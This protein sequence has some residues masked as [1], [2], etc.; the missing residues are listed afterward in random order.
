MRK[1]GTTLLEV[2]VAAVLLALIMVGMANVLVSGK[3]WIL[4]SR[5]RMTSGELGKY[6]LDPLQG[7]VRMDT[8]T[9]PSTNP[10]AITGGALRYC[11]GIGGHTQQPGG[12]CP[13]SADRTL[14]S[15]PY[16]SS[17]NISDFDGV[18]K[19]VVTLSWPRQ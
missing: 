14:D 7:S 12:F 19:V 18:R 9:D 10:L 15:V 8:W 5:S 1:K 16:S 4:H 11:D 17:Y 13:S 2:V 3:R 6:F